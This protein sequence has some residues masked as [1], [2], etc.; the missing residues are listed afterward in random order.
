MTR[1]AQV[2]AVRY[3]GNRLIEVEFNDGL[4]RQLEFRKNWLGNLECL[5][6][7]DFL[8]KVE[9]DLVAHTLC[10]PNSIDLDP[11]V[12]YGSHQP[13]TVGEYFTV[14]NEIKAISK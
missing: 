8:S 5:N 11:E 1:C 14:V 7:D 10:W 6:H 12:L 13:A 9:V 2:S 3:L 4:I